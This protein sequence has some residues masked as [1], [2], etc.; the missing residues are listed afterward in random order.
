[1]FE[2][3]DK[4]GFAVDI[5]N[6]KTENGRPGKYLA[7]LELQD[8][9][10]LVPDAVLLGLTLAGWLVKERYGVNIRKDGHCHAADIGEVNAPGQVS[11]IDPADSL[12]ARKYLC[13][14]SHL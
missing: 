13:G 14:C 7:C 3:A 1:M 8:G 5:G 9:G 6:D 4:I 12:N 2:R 10:V 11:A